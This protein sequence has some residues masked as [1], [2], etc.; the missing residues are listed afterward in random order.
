MN[1]LQ[2]KLSKGLVR[3]IIVICALFLFFYV[4]RINLNKIESDQLIFS[5]MLLGNMAWAALFFTAQSLLIFYTWHYSLIALSAKV[6][7]PVSILV[8]VSSF[9]ARYLPGGVWHIGGRLVGLVKYGVD[10]IKITVALFIEQFSAIVICLLLAM[11]LSFFAGEDTF[12]VYKSIGIVQDDYLI[13]VITIQIMLSTALVP[14]VFNWL[15][16]L[17]LGFVDKGRRAIKVKASD[18]VTIY[19]MH[20]ISLLL[21]AIA[22][23]YSIMVFS[24]DYDFSLVKV[25]SAVLLATFIGFVTPFVPGG[26]GVREAVLTALL[27]DGDNI[28]GLSVGVIVARLLMVL[29]ESL[30]FM[31][32]FIKIKAGFLSEED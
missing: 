28:I 27:A 3:I 30:I 8:Y 10:P 31:A 24:G 22:Y 4:F 26:I 2:S 7:A 5:E 12:Y 21:Y 9:V 20:L 1:I 29:V 23:Y 17:L 32:V 14:D 25:C 19:V 18:L 11:F 15:L 13:F 6:S 16:R